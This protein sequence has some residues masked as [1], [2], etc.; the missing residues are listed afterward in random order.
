MDWHIPDWASVLGFVW[1]VVAS[2]LTWR[3]DHKKKQSEMMT[4]RFLVA[5]KPS[6]TPEQI[7]A[8]NDELERIKPSKTVQKVSEHA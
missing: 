4:H 7:I 6:A 8:I 2:W 1:A 3:A 5:L